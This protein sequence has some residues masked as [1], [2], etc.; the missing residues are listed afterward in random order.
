MPGEKAPGMGGGLE[1][2]HGQC[3][4]TRRLVG[5][6]RT[7]VHIAVLPV[8]HA[9]QDLP[10][11]GFVALELIGDDH[12]WDIP[13]PFEELAE[14]L[15]GRPLSRRRCTRISRTFPSRSTARHR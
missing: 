1:P 10:L 7:I 13:A 12:P 11:G 4:L 15:L 8:F 3:P 14:E 6:L 5:V 9:R 2:P